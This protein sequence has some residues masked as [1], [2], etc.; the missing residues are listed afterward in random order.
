[1]TLAHEYKISAPT[2]ANIKKDKEK[3]LKCNGLVTF[4]GKMKKRYTGIGNIF[5]DQYLYKWYVQ[6]KRNGKHVT[7]SMIQQKALEINKVLNGPKSFKA[8]PGFLWNFTKRH[9]IEL[10]CHN[11]RNTKKDKKK[12]L[13]QNSINNFDQELTEDNAEQERRVSNDGEVI[14]S[15]HQI[16]NELNEN[17]EMVI[18]NEHLNYMDCIDNLTVINVF[19]TINTFLS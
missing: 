5:L 2:I 12:Y 11:K 6:N 9:N 16:N 18:D 13:D 10:S 19:Y 15:E 7:G 4:Q 3:L 14:Q 17:S 1:M 8:S